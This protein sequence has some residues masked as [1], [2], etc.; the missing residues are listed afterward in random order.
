MLPFP[1]GLTRPEQA[2][3]LLVPI[4][5]LMQQATA[6]TYKKVPKKVE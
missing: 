4:T 6:K 1:H 2:M 5:Y 3:P